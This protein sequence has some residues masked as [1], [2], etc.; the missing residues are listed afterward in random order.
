MLMYNDEFPPDF[1]I[2]TN[3]IKLLTGMG[4]HGLMGHL[5][6]NETKKKEREH[7]KIVARREQRVTYDLPP[8]LR[9]RIKQLA[10]EHRL[11]ASQIVTLALLRFLNDYEQGLIDISLYKQPS[12]SPRYDWNLVLPTKLLRVLNK[13]NSG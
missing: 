2:N 1:K 13:E 4:Q 12:R 3:V 9:H 6:C 10:D 7:T 11:P 8:I 5:S